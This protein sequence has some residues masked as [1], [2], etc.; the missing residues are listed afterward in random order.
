DGSLSTT[1]IVDTTATGTITSTQTI[2]IDCTGR[3]TVTVLISGTWTGRILF[4]CAVDA[5]G[6]A[7]INAVRV[8]TGAVANSATS[9]GVFQVDTTGRFKIRVHGNPVSSGT[10]SIV[11]RASATIAGS[12]V[13]VGSTLMFDAAI[14]TDP[15][16]TTSSTLA[17]SAS[18]VGTATDISNY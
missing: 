1:P 7:P 13:R 4:E 14:A 15:N 12:V 8:G 6:F 9:S 5:S 18:F 10:A 11:L 2:E 3:G 17:A 16:N